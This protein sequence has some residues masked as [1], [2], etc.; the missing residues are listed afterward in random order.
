LT[1]EGLTTQLSPEVTW[2]LYVRVRD[3]NRSRATGDEEKI[4]APDA[5]DDG[6]DGVAY[7]FTGSVWEKTE[8]QMPPFSR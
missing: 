8:D 4:Q 5:A 7:W 6:E 1:P 3:A 2:A